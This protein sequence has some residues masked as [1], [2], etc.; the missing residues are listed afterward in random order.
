MADIREEND[1]SKG[2]HHARRTQRHLPTAMANEIAENL[3]ANAKL[4]WGVEIFGRMHAQRFATEEQAQRIADLIG[5]KV[6]N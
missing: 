6:C 3:A 5:G 2:D 4:A 1:G